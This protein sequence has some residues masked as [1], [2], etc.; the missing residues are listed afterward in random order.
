MI[1]PLFGS[2]PSC[3]TGPPS[4]Q[5]P[6]LAYDVWLPSSQVLVHHIGGGVGGGAGG[7]DGGGGEGGGD[8]GGGEGG[9]D[10]GGE[11]G[12]G[13]GGGFGGGEGGKKKRE[14]QSVQSV[15]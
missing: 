3:A 8:G 1:C 9:G 12:G 6:L 4:W 10:G 14:P 7:G 15:P 5:C 13:L 11:G 2:A